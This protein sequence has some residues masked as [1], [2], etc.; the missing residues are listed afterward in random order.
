MNNIRDLLHHMDAAGCMWTQVVGSNVRRFIARCV[1]IHTNVF[2]FL[3]QKGELKTVFLVLFNFHWTNLIAFDNSEPVWRLE[4]RV[5]RVN[6]ADV[7]RVSDCSLPFSK[8][9]M[10]E[11][12]ITSN[13]P[14]VW[15]PCKLMVIRNDA[16]SRF[17]KESWGRLE[18][19]PVARSWQASE[20]DMERRSVSASFSFLNCERCTLQDSWHCF[21][22]EESLQSPPDTK[23]SFL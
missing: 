22:S 16:H 11:N 13:D 1:R 5:R 20:R 9:H 10:D 18:E 3:I 19:W 4:D 14:G 21:R 23:G 12:L 8:V 2:F 6:P 15:P 7:R 17:Q